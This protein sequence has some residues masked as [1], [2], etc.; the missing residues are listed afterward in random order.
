MKLKKRILSGVVCVFMLASYVLTLA[1]CG[2]KTEECDHHFGEWV[3]TKAATCEEEGIQSRTCEHCAEIET[4]EVEALGHDWGDATCTAPKTCKRCSATEGDAS[5]HA[6]TVEAVKSAAL[7]S[8]ATSTS[9]AIYYKSCACGEISKNDADTF[10]HGT[11]LSHTHSFTVDTV[12][13]EALKSAASCESAA[14]YYKSCSCGEIGKD[15]TF[16]SGEPLG[17]KDID[18]NHVCD[19]GCSKNDI[20]SHS[21]SKT[22]G[23]HVCDYGCSAVLESCTDLPNDGNH[24]CDI[25]GAPDVSSHIHAEATCGEPAVCTDCNTII[26]IVAHKDD[27]KDHVCDN[28]CLK[29]DIGEHSDSD[30]DDDHVCDYGCGAIFSNCSDVDTDGDHLCDV[31]GAE[32]GTHNYKED[33]S[34]ETPATCTEAAKKVHICNCGHED[35]ENIG[36]KLGH[37]IKNATSTEKHVSGCEYVYTYICQRGE[38]G[39]EVEGATVYKHAYIATIDTSAT[40]NSDGLKKY[41]CKYCG[42]TDKASEPIPADSTG[43]VWT[44]G[45]VDANGVRTDTCGVCGGTKTVTVYSGEAVDAS[46][47]KNKEIEINNANITL[48]N[49]LIDSWGEN[50]QI[51]V[52]AETVTKDSLNLNDTNLE[53]QIGDAPIYNFT[54]TDTVNDK[55]ISDFNGNKVTVTLPYTLAEGEDVDSIAVWFI[56]DSCQRNDCTAGEGCTDASH[57]LVSIPARYNNGYVTFETDHFS[58][59]TVTRLTSA[60][61]C[62]LYGH[63]YERIRIVGGCIEDSYDLCVCI[64]CHDK[65]IDEESRVVAKGHSYSTEI[66]DASCVIPGYE[67]HT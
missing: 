65:Y 27:N 64:R 30:E 28:G 7:K 13:S 63:G 45:T 25:C 62:A 5:A 10:T 15:E 46:T 66:R 9:A 55:A 11:V 44:E 22:D 59:Y 36:D 61:R 60:E 8:A 56:S 51:S 33:P 18:L 3:D 57:R 1:A 16:T 19:N 32:C 29:N 52:S 58:V 39:A 38:C 2:K 20:G 40:C 67:R 21:D 43:H 34:R 49:D 24:S 31:C 17:H 23:D 26:E 47:F 48:G 53:E 12:K 41:A 54:I 6:Y 42:N 35:I 50:A 4:T 14:V 37:D